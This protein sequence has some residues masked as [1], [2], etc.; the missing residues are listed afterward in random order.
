M[1]WITGMPS[2]VR[3]HVGIGQWHDI[4]VEDDVTCYME[5]PMVRPAHSLLPAERRPAATGLRLPAPRAVDSG[6]RTL[7]LTQRG[8]IG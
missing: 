7:T 3:S 1:Q 2:K 6:K 8:A 4:E 5:L